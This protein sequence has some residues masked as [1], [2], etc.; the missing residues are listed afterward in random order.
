MVVFES[1]IEQC[2]NII[3]YASDFFQVEGKGFILG[4]EGTDP[5]AL[6]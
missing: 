3:L 1:H 6:V 5:G 2:P 4:A